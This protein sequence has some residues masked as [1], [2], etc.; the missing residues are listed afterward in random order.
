LRATITCL[1]SKVLFINYIMH[2]EEGVFFTGRICV[3]FSKAQM[4]LYS[5]RFSDHS[6]VN[7]QYPDKSRY[8][9]VDFSLNLNL[10]TG[11]HSL[12]GHHKYNRLAN[13]QTAKRDCFVNK[14]IF[15][16][17]SRHPKPGQV[18]VLNGHFRPV[19]TLR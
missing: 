13:I 18:R 5:V 14:E 7:I 2:R 16:L 6:T 12:T 11:D 3:Q 10:V 15:S 19:P 4:I 1:S 9:M 8:R 17:Y